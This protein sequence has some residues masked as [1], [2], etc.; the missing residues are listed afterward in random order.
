MGTNDIM[1]LLSI[2]DRGIAAEIKDLLEES[3]IYTMLVT[4]NPASS[5]MGT[6]FGIN[7]SEIIEL[8]INK[9]DYR[10]AIE[11]LNDSPYKELVSN[12]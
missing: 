3:E 8:Q 10:R 1:R 4:D 11:I 6:Y 9:N 12:I 7:P 5:F 2:D